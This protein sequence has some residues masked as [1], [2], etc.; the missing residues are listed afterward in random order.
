M[1]KLEKEG[2]SMLPRSGVTTAA[3]NT[4][5]GSKAVGGMNWAA[6]GCLLEGFAIPN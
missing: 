2:R 1:M 4:A 3:E 5:S 6:T